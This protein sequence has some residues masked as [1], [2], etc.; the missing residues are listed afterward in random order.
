[1]L[2]ATT[3]SRPPEYTS[4]E[5]HAILNLSPS[6]YHRKWSFDVFH[7]PIDLFGII[8]DV[9]MVYKSSEDVINPAHETMEKVGNLLEQ[10]RN[11][12]HPEIHSGPQYHLTEVWRIAIILYTLTLFPAASPSQ[13][14]ESL[15]V[16]IFN[17]AK[18]IPSESQLSLAM[19]WPLFQAGICSM[20]PENRDWLKRYIA[21]M[22]S[23][24]GCRPFKYA[25]GRLEEAWSSGLHGYNSISLGSRSHHK[26]IIA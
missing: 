4:R 5:I 2:G 12:Q 11:W 22:T 9:T 19:S 8:A 20:A 1:V 21:T 6:E 24:Q 7:C 26:I 10:S 14:L 3:S 16:D 13:R 18:A 25:L 23:I 17:H 15:S